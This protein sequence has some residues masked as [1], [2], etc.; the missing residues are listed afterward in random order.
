VYSA[1]G[2]VSDVLVSLLVAGLTPDDLVGFQ[3]ADMVLRCLV[4]LE[5]TKNTWI[6][7]SIHTCLYGEG[8]NKV[9]RLSM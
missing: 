5:V 9:Y 8:V 7:P 6:S 4:D 2:L 1:V 3:K